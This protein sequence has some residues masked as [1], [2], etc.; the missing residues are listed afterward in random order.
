M[1]VAIGVGLALLVAVGVLVRVSVGGSSGSDCAVRLEVNSST[2]K[3]D[4]LAELAEEYNESGREL[5]GGGCAR[6]TVSETSS[7]VA[8]DA[9]A[10]GGRSSATVRRNRRCGR[11]PPR[12]G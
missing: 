6:V 12:C 1:L 10:Q 4:L 3:G 11:R 2:E 5:A 7:G 9:L 8:K